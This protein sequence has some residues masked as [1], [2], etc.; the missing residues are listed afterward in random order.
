M[1]SPDN[2]KLCKTLHLVGK[3]YQEDYKAK[4]VIVFYTG[5]YTYTVYSDIY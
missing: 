5:S 4:K 1:Y 2:R 3:C